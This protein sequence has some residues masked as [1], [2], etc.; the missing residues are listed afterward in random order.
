[1]TK[2]TRIIEHTLSVETGALADNDVIADTETMEGFFSYINGSGIITSIVLLDKADQGTA[3]DLI[4]L[5]DLVVLGT[6]NSA[7]SITDSNADAIVGG[8]SIAAG[9]FDDLIA[10]QIAMKHDLHIPVKAKE[11]TMQLFI[12]AVVRS[13]TPTYSSATNITL[14]I[15]LEEDTQD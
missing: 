6:E 8:I 12:G 4:F 10:S 2:Q 15:G 14:K 7:I 11:G 1:M 5:N 3:I 9:D 13:G